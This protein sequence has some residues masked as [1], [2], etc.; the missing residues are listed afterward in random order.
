MTEHT[1]LE[2]TE[3]HAEGVQCPNDDHAREY[4][5]LLDWLDEQLQA[6]RDM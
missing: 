3:M 4:Y 5:A 1:D 2:L 6:Q